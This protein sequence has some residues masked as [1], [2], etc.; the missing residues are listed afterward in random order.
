MNYTCYQ[1]HITSFHLDF[2][3]AVNYPAYNHLWEEL[4][5]GSKGVIYTKLGRPDGKIRKAGL[6]MF[7]QL[8]C[9]AQIRMAVQKL[10]DKNI[11]GVDAEMD[12][13]HGYWAHCFDYLR[14]IILC[15][16]DDSIE[17]SKIVA[18][19]WTSDGFGGVKEC[20]DHKWLHEITSCGEGGCEG[21]PF[22][23][24]PRSW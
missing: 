16:A 13:L 5:G 10:Q 14:Q 22:Y 21:K 6:A 15:N 1:T 17:S 3:Y 7:H 9:L 2:K 20:R 8:E 23:V 4:Q 24:K 19:K 11:T 12:G 18:G